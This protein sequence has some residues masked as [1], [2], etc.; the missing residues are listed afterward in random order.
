MLSRRGFVATS[1][2]LAGAAACGLS[3]AGCGGKQISNKVVKLREAAE[4]GDGSAWF[5]QDSVGRKVPLPSEVKTVAPSG[6]YAQLMLIQMVPERMLGLSSTFSETQRSYFPECVWNLPV[7]GKLYGGKNANLN[8]EEIIKA[9]PDVIIDVGEQK[10]DI[11]ADLDDVQTQTGLPVIYVNALL[12]NMPAAYETLG[13]VLGVQDKAR[14]MAAFTQDVLDLAADNRAA[15]RKS[16]LRVMYAGGEYGLEVKQGGTSHTAVLET[17]GLEPV[18]EAVSS[19]SGEVS[20][21]QVLN[22]D[23]DVVL[24]APYSY[25]PG[26]YSDGV[27]QK[28]S[29]VKNNHVYEVPGEPYSWIDQPPS[30]QQVLGVLWLGNLLFPELYDMDMVQVTREYYA[31]FWGCELSDDDARRLLANSTLRE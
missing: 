9:D 21:E 17:V 19:S 25:Y 20:I 10:N 23:P 7:F 12:E 13:E 2:G 31:M 11:A 27:W 30:V 28:A 1:L 15:V 5:F 26:I 8:F 3:L 4:A 18:G 14:E 22:W 6:P 16:G 29:A 24:L